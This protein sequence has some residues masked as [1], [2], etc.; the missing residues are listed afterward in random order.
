[1]SV[2]NEE[3]EAAVE[4]AYRLDLA[5]KEA[6]E[7]AD[8]ARATVKEMVIATYG[9]KYDGGTSKFHVSLN[10]TA[11]YQPGLVQYNLTEKELKKVLTLTVDRKKVEALFADRFAAGEFSKPNSPTLKITIGE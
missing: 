9:E 11:T 10:P 5:A 8:D 4:V 6:K 2:S 7:A 3:F 1:M